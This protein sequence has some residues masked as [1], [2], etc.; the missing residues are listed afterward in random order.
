MHRLLEH[1][2][3]RTALIV[4]AAVIL[5]AC[6]ATFALTQS[7]PERPT[8]AMPT[9][10]AP[11]ATTRH[12]TSPIA[13]ATTTLPSSVAIHRAP[14]A[15]NEPTAMPHGAAGMIVGIDPETGQLVLPS[16]TARAALASPALDRSM[17]G[18]TVVHKPD[19][20]KMVDLQGRFQEYMVVHIAPDGH[21][22]ESCVQGPDVEAALKGAPTATDAAAPSASDAQPTDR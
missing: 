1:H 9:P 6:I 16:K 17:A 15:T 11:A 8:T 10:A 5:G 18:L 20:S 4:V 3:R 19:G 14:K 22:V 7:R 2:P 13:G 12:Q 21:K